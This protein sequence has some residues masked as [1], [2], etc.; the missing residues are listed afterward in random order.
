MGTNFY[1]KA[2]ACPHCGHS[3]N[4]MHIGKSSC[5]W[6]FALHVIPE[7]GINCLE[8]WE[9]RWAS[10]R[11]EDEYGDALTPEAMRLRITL[12]EH[13]RGLMRSRIDGHHCVG[14]GE[15]TWDLITGEFS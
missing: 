13:P 7:E 12:R 14:H 9:A 1:L 8:D 5:G 15:G 6:A 11:I 3:N 4:R 10:G 2:D